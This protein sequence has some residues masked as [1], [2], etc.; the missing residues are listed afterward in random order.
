MDNQTY[1]PLSFSRHHHHPHRHFSVNEEEGKEEEVAEANCQYENQEAMYVF[2]ADITEVLKKSILFIS[3]VT[4]FAV[5][6]SALTYAIATYFHG[7]KK[8]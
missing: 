5:I 2:F 3:L 8:N 1:R 7:N 6:V 4:V